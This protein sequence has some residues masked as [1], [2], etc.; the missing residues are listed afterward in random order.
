MQKMEHGAMI[1]GIDFVVEVTYSFG[2]QLLH[3]TIQSGT[4][5]IG[6]AADAEIHGFVAGVRKSVGTEMERGAMRRV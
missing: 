2:P 4:S 1:L 3:D 6:D 5:F